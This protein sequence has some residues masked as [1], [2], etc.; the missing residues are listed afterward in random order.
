MSTAAFAQGLTNF[1]KSLTYTQGKFTDV[2]STDWFSM[3][4]E[5]AYEYGLMNGQT[6]TKFGASDYVKLSEVIVLA[7]RLRSIYMSDGAY[8][9]A[10][11]PWYQ[12][13]MDYAVSNGIT[14]YIKYSDLNAYA[15]RS[16]LAEI[17]A[18]CLPSAALSSINS[19]NYGDIPDVTLS[20]SYQSI[21]TLYNAGI[22]TGKTAAGNFYPSDYILRS[23]TAAII[24]RMANADLRVL[25]TISKSGS[26]GTGAQ[27][28]TTIDAARDDL[29]EAIEYYNDAYSQTSSG[30]LTSAASLLDKAAAKIQMAAQYTQTAAE[31]SKTSSLYSGVYDVLNASY[32]KCIEAIS[33]L[34]KLETASYSPSADWSA[35]RTLLTDSSAGLLTAYVAVRD[36]G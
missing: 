18:A 26:A 25:F 29:D 36:K 9:A 34:S 33:D 28:L 17:L 27:L 7:A 20:G 16:Q 5:A 2:A 13:Y 31:L 6:S 22:L 10:S 32:K 3:N 15:T 14:T 23:E 19:V 35:G 21:Y 24:T 30:Y 11:T 8:F 4:V 12:S 1:Q